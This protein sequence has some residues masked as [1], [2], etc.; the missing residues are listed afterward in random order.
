MVLQNTNSY[1]LVKPNY[2]F[3]EFKKEQEYDGPYFN[4]VA[5]K[6]EQQAFVLDSVTEK[7]NM[8]LTETK[9]LQT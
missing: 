6:M 1:G 4:N 9:Q 7:L 5:N 2:E 3:R 8:L